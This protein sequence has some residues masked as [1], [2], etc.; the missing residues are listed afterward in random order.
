M[1]QPKLL[2][3][4]AVSDRRKRFNVCA[5]SFPTSSKE[6]LHSTLDPLAAERVADT[7]LASTAT[8]FQFRVPAPTAA[9]AIAP[10]NKAFT[11]RTTLKKAFHM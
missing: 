8:C 9:P 11:C 1:V 6:S 4:Q 7:T 2:N 5:A 10:P 3:S